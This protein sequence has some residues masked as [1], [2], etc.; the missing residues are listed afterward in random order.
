MEDAINTINDVSLSSVYYYLTEDKDR[1][2]FVRLVSTAYALGGARAKRMVNGWKDCWELLEP[3]RK[4]K[5]RQDRKIEQAPAKSS[6]VE[7][8]CEGTTKSGGPCKYR[9]HG[10]SKYCKIHQPD[11]KK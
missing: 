7:V 6:E 4:A 9:A 1:E 10:E 11:D 8:L 5:A 2:E 3:Y